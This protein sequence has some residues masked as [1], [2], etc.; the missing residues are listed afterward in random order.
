ME[1]DFQLYTTWLPLLVIVVFT[2]LGTV[3]GALREAILAAAI[4]LASFTN[5]QWGDEWGQGLA[6]LPFGW[7]RN[8][9][10]F[11]VTLAVLWLVVVVIGYG[12]GT[13]LPRGRL[14]PGFRLGGALLGLASGAAV[15]GASLRYA[16]AYLD[17]AQSTSAFY[18]NPFSQGLMIW[19]AWYPIVLA[20]IG[21]I[22]VLMGPL[23]RVQSAVSRPSATTD[24]T[25]AAAVRTPPPETMGS[26][27]GT[28]API[29]S[30]MSYPPPTASPY[31]GA[32]GTAGTTPPASSTQTTVMQEVDAP[33]TALL[34]T[35]ENRE[36][37]PVVEVRPSSA[38]PTGAETRSFTTSTPAAP[39]AETDAIAPGPGLAPSWLLEPVQSSAGTTDSGSA[40]HSQDTVVQ[41]V[42]ASTPGQMAETAAEQARDSAGSAEKVC[43]NCGSPLLPGAA[44]CTQCGIRLA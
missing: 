17:N 34:P 1:A 41:Q 9:A 43:P 5:L 39:G 22:V 35:S 7:D 16:F 28:G 27:T 29:A 6:D 21:A 25:P 4:V 32:T 23:R 37:A 13:Y 42:A 40:D 2:V 19:A 14:S 12:L 33:P 18:T 44:F 26:G 15:A 10:Q 11:G 3:R 20:V 31:G 36:M 38:T 30:Y 8:T 24:W